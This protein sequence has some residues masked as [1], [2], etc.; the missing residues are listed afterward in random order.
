MFL[1]SSCCT[2]HYSLGLGKGVRDKHEKNFI[3]DVQ[4]DR[5]LIKNG[6]TVLHMLVKEYILILQCYLDTIINMAVSHEK[7]LEFTCGSQSQTV[8]SWKGII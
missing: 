7:D 1:D 8:K 2:E 6:S 4:T 5:K 3:R